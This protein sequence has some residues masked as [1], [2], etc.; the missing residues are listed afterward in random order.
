MAAP[1]SMENGRAL[2]DSHLS[3]RTLANVEPANAKK[4]VTS[5]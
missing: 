3:R 5:K 2:I 1:C 4:Q